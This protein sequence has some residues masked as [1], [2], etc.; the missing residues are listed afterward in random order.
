[1][2]DN[3]NEVH[4]EWILQYHLKKIVSLTKLMLH[5]ESMLQLFRKHSHIDNK[6]SVDQFKFCFWEKIALI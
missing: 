4:E 6:I 5:L 2:C 1:M 3:D